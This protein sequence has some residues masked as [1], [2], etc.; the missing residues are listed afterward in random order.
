MRST[1]GISVTAAEGNE[2]PRKKRRGIPKPV[3]ENSTVQMLEACHRDSQAPILVLGVGNS[4][5]S[6][7][8]AGLVLLDEL[9]QD[10]GER[11]GEVEFLDGGTQGLALLGRIARRAA[12]LILDAVQ[13]GAEPGTVHVVRDWRTTVA[14]AATAHESNVSEL[15]ATSGLMGECPETVVI[16][17]IEPSCTT[18]GTGLSRPVRSAMAGAIETARDVLAEMTAAPWAA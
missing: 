15:L 8:G 4:L 16:V 13:L 3:S 10:G 12:L 1:A 17:G 14:R 9:S 5:L 7:D 18:T 2:F 11:G 6:D